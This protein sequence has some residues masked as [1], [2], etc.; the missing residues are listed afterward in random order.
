MRVLEKFFINHSSWL[1][2][3]IAEFGS[4]ED[5]TRP[6]SLQVYRYDIATVTL[7]TEQQKILLCQKTVEFVFFKL[8]DFLWKLL[9]KENI[10]PR[11]SYKG[12]LGKYHIIDEYKWLKYEKN[13]PK[14]LN[15]LHYL[16]Y[17]HNNIDTWIYCDKK[18]IYL[19]VGRALFAQF[20]PN[21]L[22]ND[23]LV[24]EYINSYTPLQFIV[25]PYIREQLCE[26]LDK[27]RT[28]MELFISPSHC[29]LAIQ[30]AVKD[31]LDSSISY[32]PRIRDYCSSAPQSFLKRNEVWIG[33]G[34]KY[35]PFCRKRLPK[36]LVEKRMDI[37][38]KEY[39]I[40]DPY[41]SEQK[42]L[43]PQEFMTDEWWKKRGL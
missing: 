11:K 6:S 15:Y 7:H 2:I 18:H 25:F 30:G 29:C 34:F 35:C 37:L 31:S 5:V 19:E 16:L 17:A 24:K 32:D 9:K 3:A 36:D 14:A 42:K 10:L 8:N 13:M 1:E 23:P 43:I 12:L 41:D 39:G 4:N 40:D 20:D 27:C 22:P 38:E 26:W 28:I 21:D 33:Y